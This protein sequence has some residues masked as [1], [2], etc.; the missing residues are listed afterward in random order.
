MQDTGLHELLFTFFSSC[1]PIGF[2]EQLGIYESVVRFLQNLG[3]KE[4][5]FLC[6]NVNMVSF[7]PIQIN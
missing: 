6:L 3:S 5:I 4:Y 2:L 7:I 1:R